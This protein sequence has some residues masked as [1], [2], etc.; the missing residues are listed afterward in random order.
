MDNSDD[1]NHRLSLSG[2]H[3]RF[4]V[5]YKQAVDYP[6]DLYYMMDLSL[7][8]SDDRDKLSQLGDLLGQ[9]ITTYSCKPFL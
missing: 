2:S 5:T 7:S 8:M 9:F 4:N 3:V 1:E 6:V